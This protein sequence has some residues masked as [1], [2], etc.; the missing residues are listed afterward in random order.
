MRIFLRIYVN[1]GEAQIFCNL[2]RKDGNLETITATIDTGAGICLFPK[3][4]L[5]ILS[6]RASGDEHIV[7]DQAGIAGQF[8]DAVEA[9]VSISLEDEFGNVTSIFEVPVWFADTRTVLIGFTGVLDRAVLHI[10]MLQQS[11]HSAS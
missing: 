6:Y 4:L 5:E 2:L 11:D 1:P 10:D 3:E 7:I 9:F 8:F